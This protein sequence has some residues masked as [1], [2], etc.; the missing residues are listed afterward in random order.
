MSLRPW[1]N[2][3]LVHVHR[4]EPR[5]S[6]VRYPAAA[7]LERAQ[8]LE[9]HLDG[10]GCAIDPGS[11]FWLDNSPWVESLNGDWKFL[12][13]ASP[14]EAPDSLASPEID[15]ENWHDMPV[16]SHWQLKGYGTPWYTNTVYPINLDPPRVPTENPTGFYRRTFEVSSGWEGMSVR[17]RFEG[18]DSYFDCWVNGVHAGTGKG[19]RLP[20]EFDITSLLTP[21]PNTLAVRVL[22]W[23]DSTYV[24]DQ[25][26][27]WLS[28]IFRDVSLCAAPQGAAQDVWAEASYDA[29]TGRGTV[30]VH[31]AGRATLFD[32]DNQWVKTGSEGAARFE[33]D[34]V[35]PWSAEVPSLYPLL[36]ETLDSQGDPIEAIPLL[37]GFKTAEVSGDV[38]LFNGQPIKLQGVNRHD[39]DPDEG[40]AVPFHQMVRDCQLMKEHNINTV[41]TSHYPNHPAFYG[42]CDR[43]GLYVIDECDLETHGFWCLPGTSWDTPGLNPVFDPD[44]EEALVDRMARMVIRDRSHPSIIMWS[45]GN[46][47]GS[48]EA[49]R[50]MAAEARRLDPGR[51]IHYEGDYSSETGDVWSRMYT[52]IL[53]CARIARREEE[54]PNHGTQP[55]RKPYFLCEYAHA[56]GN[57]PGGLKEY[58]DE[59]RSSTRM[60]GG[61]IWEWIDHGLRQ[62][63]A[64]GRE[65]YAYGGDFGDEPNDGNFVCD[66]LLF[67]DRTPSPGLKEYAAI[68]APVVVEAVDIRGLRFRATSR[69]YFRDQVLKAFVTVRNGGQTWRSETSL[70]PLPAQGYIEFE[71]D[72]ASLALTPA[73]P[74]DD[75]ER[76]CGILR[77][78][79]E[80]VLRSADGRLAGQIVIGDC[81]RGPLS[82]DPGAPLEAES[83]DCF[84]SDDS[85]ILWDPVRGDLQVWDAHE[86]PV[87]LSGPRFNLWRAPTDNDG[88][89]AGVV[90]KWRELLLNQLGRRVESVEIQHVDGGVLIQKV[91]NWGPPVKPLGIRLTWS[92]LLAGDR[93]ID[94]KVAG[95]PWGPWEG[96]W[97]RIGVVMELPWSAQNVIASSLDQ[98]SYP[99]T[100]AASVHRPWTANVSELQTPYV[101]PQENGSRMEALAI[102]AGDLRILPHQPMSF[103]LRPWSDHD[104]TKA[105][106]ATDLVEQ[107]RLYLNLD[108]VQHGIG[109]G[110]CGPDAFEEV[111]L[112]PRDFSFGF[113]LLRLGR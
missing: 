63:D 20:H 81:R 15:A 30:V 13:F 58:W 44:Y 74:L 21:G 68:L 85:V 61:C 57:G 71:V 50:A 47:S 104:L 6:F 28:G 95:V 69:L 92:I 33:L 11:P 22:Q 60:M 62:K 25:D 75:W 64:Q 55:D 38:F 76:E 5:G 8:E 113:T 86:G 31:G 34:N 32:G 105:R 109:S 70:P 39:H 91:E 42:L 108:L 101:F 87:M 107:D 1:E 17:L 40:R 93:L 83:D 29:E 73:H 24:E 26:M 27:W 99:D 12:Y 79:V 37:T 96:V 41:R 110:S 97:P 82:L 77:D 94:V 72:R 48:G 4:L 23:S 7:G 10:E 89:W 100:R 3:R 9:G 16:P 2:P 14:E 54:P 88:T 36:V 19:S 35:R 78:E 52:G 65:F 67:P 111:R 66:G 49:H 80:V 112:T 46:E 90:Q 56:M 43:F 59:F 106:H 53:D 18:V 103:S 102:E 45:L 98:E 51:L 84:R